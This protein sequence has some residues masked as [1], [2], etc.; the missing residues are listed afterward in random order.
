[1]IHRIIEWSLNNRVIVI[2]LFLGI[3]GFGYWALLHTP[4]DAIP[5]VSENQVIVFTDWAGRSPQEVEDQITYPLVTNLQGLPGVKIVRAN[6]AF[7]FSMI[8]I[9]FEDNVELYWARTRILE[10]LNVVQSQLPE[11]VTPT[12]GPDA[13][14]VGQVFW[15]TLESDKYNLKELRT[16]QDWFVRYQLNSV[17][18]VAEVASVGGHVQQYQIDVDP[19][20]LRGYGMPVSKVIEAVKKSNT[21]VGGNVVEQSGQWAIVRGIGLIESIADVE[22]IVIGSSNGTPI[23]VKNVA[24]VKIGDAFRVGALDKN[25]KEAVGGVVIARYGVN[26]LEVIDAAK[27]KIKEIEVG[28]PEGVTIVP[29]YDRTQL[30]NR[31]TDTLKWTLIEELLLVTIVMV[32]FLAHFRSV[33]IVTIPLPL[34]VLMSFSFMYFMGIT[35]NIMSLAGI[36]IA[37]GVLV[38]AGIVVTEN[39]FRFIEK[40]NIDPKDKKAVWNSVLESTKLVGRPVFFSMAII[41]LAF[42]PVFALEGR[43]GKLFHPLAF[44]KTFAMIGSTIIA[45]S[46]VPVLCT[47]LLGGKMRSE[48]SNPLMRILQKL[49]EPALLFALRNRVIAVSIALTLFL[50]AV[51]AGSTIGSEFMPNLNEGDLMYMPVTDPA[52]S[53]NEALKILQQEDRIIKSFPEVEWAVGKVG[54]A[55]T[56][57]DPAPVSMNE[58]IIHLKPKSEWRPG[59]TRESLIVEMDNALKLP[60]VTN[61]WTQPI[62]GRIEMLATGI[63]TEIGIKIFGDD[64]ETL[65]KLSN[66]VADAVKEVPGAA[67]IYPEKVIGTPYLDIDINRRAAARYGIDVNMINEAI[68]KGIGE[69]NLSITIEGRE[70]FPIRVRYAPEFRDSVENIGQIPLVL[71]GG[72]SIPLSQVAEIRSVSGASMIASE[73]GLLKG[74]VLLNVRGRDLGSFVAE[75]DQVVKQKVKMPGGYFIT[76][77]GQFENQQRAKQRLLLV[78]PLVL[79][80]IFGLLYITY[81][82]AVEAAHVLL[83]VPFALT[84]GV[85]LQWLLGYNFSVAVWVGFIA[86]FGTAVQT[87]VVM[88]IYLEEAVQKKKEELGFLDKKALLDAVIE[89]ALLRL[90]PKVM[91]VTTV[92][93]GLLPIMWSTSTGAEVMKP[94]ATPVLGGMVSSLLHV[95]IITPVIFYWIQEKRLVRSSELQVTSE[96]ENEDVK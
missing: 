56:S 6:S 65:E 2:A 26:T 58:T 1:M 15:Y 8:N 35:S 57:T 96:S 93:A 24:E 34:A 60:G 67:D 95:L 10:R 63:R 86:L 61:I 83:A 62:I 12:L 71:P 28:L 82:S 79:V 47:F 70:R 7:S 77:S 75:A 59:V 29:F 32:V 50:G 41:I 45:V 17:V 89:G 85:Y 23:Y 88:V 31:A 18:G 46:L 52:I 53:M 74:T 19:N 22:N 37:I 11:G 40:N 76:W 87:G 42:I 84:G 81:N 49:Y 51:Y 5:D 64:L 43:E 39:A 4:I 36:A 91:T 14:G 69:T 21:N 38:D 55:D 30:I 68:E 73:N 92:V 25:G 90:R 72:M 27:R 16:M 33:L 9:I 13:T 20:E 78:I 48:R 66:E 54:R 80:V 94:L 3:G 44:T